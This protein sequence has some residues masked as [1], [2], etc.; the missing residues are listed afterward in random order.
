VNTTKLDWNDKEIARDVEKILR[1]EAA[2]PRK[3]VEALI[4]K[5]RD[6][7]VERDEETNKA[8]RLAGE[9]MLEDGND[10]KGR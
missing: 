7:S 8:L 2:D 3:I 9:G 6:L 10:G 1:N 4:D 5:V